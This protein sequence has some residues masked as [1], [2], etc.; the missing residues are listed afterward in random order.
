[1]SPDLSLAEQAFVMM[2]RMKV[3][4]RAIAEAFQIS[5]GDAMRVRF[6]LSLPDRTH[7]LDLLDAC[8]HPQ[9]FRKER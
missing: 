3:S 2:W 6:N 1:M 8:S 9:S 7:A 4:L 5:L